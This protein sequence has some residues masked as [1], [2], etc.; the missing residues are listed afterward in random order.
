MFYILLDD[1]TKA[2]NGSTGL[3]LFSSVLN[4][5]YSVISYFNILLINN[6]V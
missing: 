3:K 1:I 4:V 5:F 2:L 6:Y